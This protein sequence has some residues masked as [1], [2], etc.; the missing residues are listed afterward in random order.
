GARLPDHENLA[1]FFFGDHCDSGH[2]REPADPLVPTGPLGNGTD[3]HASPTRTRKHGVEPAEALC[4]DDE[5]ALGVQRREDSRCGKVACSYLIAPPKSRE[6]R[7][8]TGARGLLRFKE[9]PTCALAS[10]QCALA[11]APGPEDGGDGCVEGLGA[12]R[13]ERLTDVRVDPIASERN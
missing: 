8:A 5:R 6:G 7:D 11:F 2:E 12:A 4:N 3:L 13:D 9:K 10:R 1:H